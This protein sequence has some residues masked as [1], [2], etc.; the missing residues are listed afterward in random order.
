MVEQIPVLNTTFFTIDGRVFG[1]FQLDDLR[2]M[3]H[4]PEPENKYNKAFMEKFTTKN[5]T[6]SASIWQWRQ[7]P[8][9]HKNESSSK[10]SVD[11]LSS[12]YCYIGAMMCRIWGMHDSAKFNIE[13][14][15]LMEAAISSYVMDWENILLDKL[16]S[17]ILEFR[18]N[19]CKT[20]RT[21]PPLLL[22]YLC[23]GCALL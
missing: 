9:R 1:S 5:E 10:Y 19:S 15:P 4:F 8:T 18:F 21:I 7:N 2:K 22:Q 13:I 14:V 20:T 6:E 12:P 17:T 23:Y 16:A 11:S 3:Y